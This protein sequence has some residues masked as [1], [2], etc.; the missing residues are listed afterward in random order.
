MANR[1]LSI[2]IGS[3]IT[4]VVEV[5]HKAKY[6]QIYR[7]FTFATPPDM[8]TDGNVNINE[9]FIT[10][11]K[12]NLTQ[13]KINT[14]Q[15]IFVVNSTRVA[16]RTVQ[17][18]VVKE[19]RVG[20]LLKSNASDYFP[21]DLSQYELSHEVLGQVMEGTEK[22]LQVSILAMPK[23]IIGSYENLARACGLTL[24]GL[25]Y[26]GNCIKKLMIREIPEEIKV[27]IKINEDTTI[28]TFMEGDV[29]QLQRTI[30]YGIADTINYVQQSQ[31]NRRTMDANEAFVFLRRKIC[32]LRRFD[33]ANA[34]LDEDTDRDFE[35]DA[36]KMKQ[37]RIDVTDDLRPMMGSIARVLDY[38]QASH[39]DKKFDTI[40]LAGIGSACNGIDKL[41]TNEL[42]F[43]VIAV[44]QY[45]D[46]SMSKNAQ[47]ENVHVAEYFGCIGA[48]LDPLSISFGDKKGDRKAASEEKEKESFTLAVVACGVCVIVAVALIGYSL[49]SNMLLKGENRSLTAQV[50]QLSYIDQVVAEYDAAKANN[51][52][53]LALQAATSSNNDNLVA[54]I[55]ELETKMPSEINVLTLSASETALNLN[56]EV[57]SKAAVA[58]I[59]SQLRTFD[60]IVVGNVSTITDT[61]DEAGVSVVS[62]SVDCTY[63][64]VVSDTAQAAAETTTDSGTADEDLSAAE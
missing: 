47:R 7:V 54:F 1:V 18:P 51:D 13:Y 29:I 5:D 20:E 34:G 43:K 22:K 24:V 56:I 8:L 46:M 31:V 21:V 9:S 44:Q 12:G 40:Y 48:A 58:D 62:F 59:I 39:S 14:K 26:L 64:G 6:P 36:A 38:Y 53:A 45:A 42:G 17:I 25:D 41:M 16:S 49:V 2:E 27:T 37:L 23:D 10:L 11:L 4:R 52:W 35:V 19:N 33:Q 28:I 15:V 60:S 61:E 55:E 50:N 3:V 57:T 63:I 30:N 32:I